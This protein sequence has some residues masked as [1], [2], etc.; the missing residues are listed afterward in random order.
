VPV[1]LHGARYERLYQA[2]NLP[3]ITSWMEWQCDVS[4]FFE[5]LGNFVAGD[6]DEMNLLERHDW[7]GQDRGDPD[8]PMRVPC[9]LA[10]GG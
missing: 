4:L 6:W 8:G 1:C 2:V 3:L 9:R 7:N 10:V 5:V